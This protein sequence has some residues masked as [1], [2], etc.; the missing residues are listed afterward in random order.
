MKKRY[1]HY[2]LIIILMATGSLSGHIDNPFLPKGCASCHVGHGMSNQPMI[3]KAEENS[4]YD[5]HGSDARR[6]E[7][8]SKGKLSSGAPVNDIEKVFKKPYRHPVEEGLAHSPTEVLPSDT[9][10]SVSHA[11]C[12]DCH[13]PH[14]RIGAGNKLSDVSGYTISGQRKKDNVYEYEICLKCHAEYV[15][16]DKPNH[17]LL[18]EF[19]TSVN[20]QHPVTRPATGKN[21]ESL[22]SGAIVQATM[23]CSD[24]HTNDDPDGPRGPHGSNYKYMLS[25][26]YDTDIYASESPY[27]FEFCYSCH[28][29]SSIL[30]DDSFPLHRLH[31]LG[32]PLRNIPGTSCF[33]CHSSHSSRINPFLIDFNPKAVSVDET[34]RMIRYQSFGNKNGECYLK[35]HGVSHSPARY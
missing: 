25:G 11:E 33:T 14:Q 35:C 27:A 30:S 10:S 28:E 4:C 6:T 18:A 3:E 16:L 19:S 1:K 29:R 12:V 5:C 15:G 8:I 13:N 20:S 24:C 7:M 26:N 34:T 9:K 22:S 32:D 31:I 2:T 21:R 17:D 23:E